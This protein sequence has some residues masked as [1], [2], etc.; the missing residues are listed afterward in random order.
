MELRGKDSELHILEMQP[1]KKVKQ[2]IQPER[3]IS[4]SKPKSG[5]LHCRVCSFSRMHSEGFSFIVWGSG[6][7]T[8]V[9]LQL[10]VASFSRRFSRH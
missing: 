3:R 4:E 9:R 10:V 6:G 5:E 7:W 1:R 8:L 2:K